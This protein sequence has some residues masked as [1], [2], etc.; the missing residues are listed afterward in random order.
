MRCYVI[1]VN[2]EMTA[3]R[4][5]SNT[6]GV[7]HTCPPAHP[8]TRPLTCTKSLHTLRPLTQ[9]LLAC[10]ATLRDGDAM[11]SHVHASLTL[12]GTAAN[13]VADSPMVQ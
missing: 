12:D 7:I 2:V 11:T 10:Q 4:L 5:L 13:A 8:P 9:S 6:M 1:A 3:K